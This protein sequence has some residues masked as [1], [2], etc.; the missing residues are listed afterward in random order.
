[1]N[2][3]QKVKVTEYGG[4]QLIRRVVVDRG[5]SVVV[6]NEEEYITAEKQRRQPEGVGFPIRAVELL[7]SSTH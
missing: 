7:K 5:A 2:P 3:G 4:R 6:C 1:M